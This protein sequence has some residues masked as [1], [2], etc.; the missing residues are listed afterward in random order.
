MH[1]NQ[2]HKKIEQIIAKWHELLSR[3]SINGDLERAITK[4]LGIEGRD[5]HVALIA[6]NI[7]NGDFS[8]L[9]EHEELPTQ[10]ILQHRN[11]QDIP[12]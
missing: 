12:K 3:W 5:V 11:E 1:T 7:S 10:R 9:P 2:E 4:A 6:N 8:V